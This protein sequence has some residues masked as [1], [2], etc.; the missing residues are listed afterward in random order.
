MRCDNCGK[1]AARI[2]VTCDCAEADHH[3]HQVE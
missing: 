1:G 2:A 3:H